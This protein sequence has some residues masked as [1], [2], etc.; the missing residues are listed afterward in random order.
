VSVANPQT[1]AADP[2]AARSAADGL[3]ATIAPAALVRAVTLI[4][5]YHRSDHYWALT[6][7]PQYRGRPLAAS[8]AAQRRLAILS[9]WYG[10]F[11]DHEDAEQ[12]DCPAERPPWTEAAR[13]LRRSQPPRP[14]GDWHPPR[15]RRRWLSARVTAAIGDHVAGRATARAAWAPVAS[16]WCP[17][18]YWRSVAPPSRRY[19]RLVGSETVE[20]RRCLDSAALRGVDRARAG[21]NCHTPEAYP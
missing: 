10:Y 19:A 13:P 16:H 14:A 6:N 5:R 1:P 4:A 21:R 20:K 17:G 2:G 15:H 9:S 11:A 12:P 7:T 18:T 8:S 3:D